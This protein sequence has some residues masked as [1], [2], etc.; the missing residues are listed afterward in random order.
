MRISQARRRFPRA[1]S[2]LSFA[3][4]LTLVLAWLAVAPVGRAASDAADNTPARAYLIADEKYG[5]ILAGAHT[6][7]KVQIASLTKIATAVVAF[8]WTRLGGHSLDQMVAIRAATLATSGSNPVGYEAG[9]ELTIRDLLYAVLLQ[10]DNIAA[11]TLADHIGRSLPRTEDAR[12]EDPPSVH[13]V[14][15][16]NALARKLGMKRTLFLNATGFDGKEKPYSTALDLGRLT[17]HA[18][19]K[20]EFRFVVAQKE[21]RITIQRAGQPVGYLLRNT[22]DLL[23]TRNI[24]GVK[25]GQTAKAGGCLIITAARE[26]IV[27]KEGDR[28]SLLQRRLIVIVLGSP[29][30]SQVAAGLLERGEALFDAWSQAG[31]LLEPKTTL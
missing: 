19:S 8:D 1:A 2:L 30:R 28:P 11:E 3:P 31:R 24:D 25:T 23:G 20:A 16:M 26:P 14:A 6:E 5:H 27:L 13:F 7:D 12:R 15:Q 10:S 17:R 29:N 18:M 21:R 9:D 4:F 22:N